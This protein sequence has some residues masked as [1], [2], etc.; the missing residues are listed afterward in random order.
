MNSSLNAL[1]IQKLI[2]LICLW[3]VDLGWRPGGYQSHSI[4]PLLSWTG[5][6]K[7]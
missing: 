6:G 5:E 3:W 2:S 7:I 1:R 4:A